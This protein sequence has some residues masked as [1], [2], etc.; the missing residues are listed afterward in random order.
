MRYHACVAIVRRREVGWE[1]LWP[2]HT[3]QKD[4]LLEYKVQGRS[5]A[6]LSH[7]PHLKGSCPDPLDDVSSQ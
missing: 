1:V 2:S 6:C 4:R 5:P 7:I 3:W